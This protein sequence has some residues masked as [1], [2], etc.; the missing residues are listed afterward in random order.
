MGLDEGDV[1]II[2]AIAEMFLKTYPKP[3][4]INITREKF[5]EVLREEGVSPSCREKLWQE[6]SK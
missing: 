1:K 5:G 4:S 3:E 6:L 2:R